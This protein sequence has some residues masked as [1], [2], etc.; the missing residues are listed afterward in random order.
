[1]TKIEKYPNV[2]NHLSAKELN[3]GIKM[4]L[5]N[6]QKVALE[7]ITGKPWN[8]W[9][10]EAVKGYFAF[11]DRGQH[12][13]VPEEAKSDFDKLISYHKNHPYTVECW[14]KD[15]LSDFEKGLP[16]LLFLGD[17][18]LPQIDYEEWRKQGYPEEIP[19]FMFPD[20]YI[21]HA[22]EVYKE[23]RGYI[24]I[25][26]FSGYKEWANKLGVKL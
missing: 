24:P 22:F 23:V 16:P 7:K 25:D 14:K 15:F 2:V 21:K 6:K 11:T 19:T 4:K 26:E 3:T 5:S 20:A 18:F 8:S 13:E 9:H 12:I 10:Q 17:F 1:M